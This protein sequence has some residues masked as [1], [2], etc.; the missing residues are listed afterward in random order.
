MSVYRFFPRS[1]IFSAAVG[2]KAGRGCRWPL[3]TAPVFLLQLV[4]VRVC[5]R[6]IATCSPVATQGSTQIDPGSSRLT[7]SFPSG[8]KSG[9]RR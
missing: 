1:F 3:R 2:E 9:L 7:I 5:L 4:S 8:K 6:E